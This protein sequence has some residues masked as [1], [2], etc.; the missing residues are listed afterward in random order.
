MELLNGNPDYIPALYGMA[1]AYVLLKQPP[2][3]RNQ[4]KRVAKM[5]WALEYAD[6]IEKSWI[7]LAD[8]YIQVCIL[9]LIHREE[10]MI[11]RLSS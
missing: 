5:D 11:L 4:L 2:R 6:D 9:M 3:A 1:A 7:L 8:L 10:N